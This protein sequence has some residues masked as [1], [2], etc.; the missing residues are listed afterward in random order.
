MHQEQHLPAFT[1]HQFS[2]QSTV[3]IQRLLHLQSPD[4]ITLHRTTLKTFHSSTNIL[5]PRNFSLCS[6]GCAVQFC[7]HLSVL[8]FHSYYNFQLSL[9]LLR[10]YTNVPMFHRQAKLCQ[11]ECWCVRSSNHTTMSSGGKHWIGKR[12]YSKSK[13]SNLKTSPG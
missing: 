4:S 13:C 7:T 6:A 2:W 12:S 10:D 11:R 3:E 9:V 5:L 8:R 1:C